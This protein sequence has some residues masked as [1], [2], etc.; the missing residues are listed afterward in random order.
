MKTRSRAHTRVCEHTRA[1]AHQRTLDTTPLSRKASSY[2]P[3][4]NDGRTRAAVVGAP[5][6]DAGA[7]AAAPGSA[8]R[9]Q[10]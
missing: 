8:A 1:R 4:V 2:T 7:D 10:L 3:G 9:R 6:P 5:S